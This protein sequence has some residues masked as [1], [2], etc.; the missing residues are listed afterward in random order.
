MSWIGDVLVIPAR[1]SALKS[2]KID[3]VA[4]QQPA[5][6]ATTFQPVCVCRKGKKYGT[7]VSPIAV[8]RRVHQS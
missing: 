7:S 5:T 8:S 1:G 6:L 4:V 2:D 3:K